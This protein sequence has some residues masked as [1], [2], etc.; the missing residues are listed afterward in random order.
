MFQWAFRIKRSTIGVK[1]N[2]KSTKAKYNLIIAPFQYPSI[3]KH[4]NSADILLMHLQ[5]RLLFKVHHEYD[6]III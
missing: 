1:F 3:S 5:T 2:V 4:H 6:F